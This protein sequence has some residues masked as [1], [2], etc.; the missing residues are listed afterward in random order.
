M[1][2]SYTAKTADGPRRQF[3]PRRSPERFECYH[4]VTGPT[5]P[6][7]NTYLH[8]ERSWGRTGYVAHGHFCCIR[9]AIQRTRIASR[10]L[11]SY[12]AMQRY[13]WRYTALYSAIQRYTAIHRYTLYNRMQ[14]PS[15]AETDGP[16]RGCT[17]SYTRGSEPATA[18]AK[19]KTGVI[20]TARVRLRA[21]AVGGVR[22]TPC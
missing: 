14:H 20:V 15:A 22:S 13:T 18:L 8:L 16:L 19:V 6:H 1:Y 9:D 11:R 21:A 10:P 17:A 7:G 4:R 3:S 2:S 5:R 12:T